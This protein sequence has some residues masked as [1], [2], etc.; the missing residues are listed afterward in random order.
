MKTM[1]NVQYYI[2]SSI[3]LKSVLVNSPLSSHDI[4]ILKNIHAQVILLPSFS[5][6]AK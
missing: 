6:F 5:I 4:F 2:L 3:S 1:S